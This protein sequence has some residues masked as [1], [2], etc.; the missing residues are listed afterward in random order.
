M[1]EKE[2]IINMLDCTTCGHCI[3]FPIPEETAIE[4]GTG[5]PYVD[6]V[7]YNM[8]T[9]LNHGN[10]C[11]LHTERQQQVQDDGPPFLQRVGV[12]ITIKEGERIPPLYGMFYRDFAKGLTYCTLMPFN[13]LMR[14][15]ITLV[16]KIRFGKSLAGLYRIHKMRKAY[17][18]L[19]DSAV[20]DGYN[21][22]IPFDEFKHF[23]GV[24]DDLYLKRR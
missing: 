1:K 2:G 16:M 18:N 23:A 13:V 22:V 3:V 15:A 10:N 19:L 24:L 4:K 8:L 6:C 7:A 12:I 14:W 17:T 11:P 9:P 21:L 5:I 20:C